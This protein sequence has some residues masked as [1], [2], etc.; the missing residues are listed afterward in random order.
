MLV[1]YI[2]N[3]LEV[4]NAMDQI[5]TKINELGYTP[6]SIELKKIICNDL[7]NKGRYYLD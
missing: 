1:P 4:K 6:N 2:N 3:E 7:Y 5:N